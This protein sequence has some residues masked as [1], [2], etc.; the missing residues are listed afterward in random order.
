MLDKKVETICKQTGYVH[1]DK[2]P[3]EVVCQLDHHKLPGADI[4]A[5]T[6]LWENLMNMTAKEVQL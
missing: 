2:C 5:R 3:L 1:C 4:R 6:A